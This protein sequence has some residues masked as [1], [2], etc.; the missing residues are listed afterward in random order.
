MNIDIQIAGGPASGK[1]IITAIIA[2]ALRGLNLPV[3]I[4]ETPGDDPTAYNDSDRAARAV[5]ALVRNGT[6]INIIARQKARTED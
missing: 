3:E 2:S 6:K 5:N 4:T 1:S